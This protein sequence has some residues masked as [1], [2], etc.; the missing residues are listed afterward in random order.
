MLK[1]FRR[2]DPPSIPQLAIPIKVPNM[3][4]EA[5]F[6]PSA[7]ANT[8]A[9]GCLILIAFISFYELENTPNHATFIAMA[10]ESVLL[11]LNNLVLGMLGF[12]K[13]EPLFNE[14]H[15]YKFSLIATVPL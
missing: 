8:Q 6:T 14:I 2:E 15:H 7:N 12:S 10:K 1:G 13:M 9:G 4:F 11:A 3:C 5:A